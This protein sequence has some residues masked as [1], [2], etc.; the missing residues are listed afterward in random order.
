M[1]AFL[2]TISRST[3]WSRASCNTSVFR[4]SSLF[5]T[6]EEGK[7]ESVGECEDLMSTLAYAKRMRSSSS[8]SCSQPYSMLSLALP[9]CQHN[10]LHC[11]RGPKE[12]LNPSVIA[13]KSVTILFY[14]SPNSLGLSQDTAAFSLALAFSIPVVPLAAVSIAIASHLDRR[15]LCR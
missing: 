6:E 1:K 3:N 11:R 12:A 13:H 7:L 2:P 5:D 15:T 4:F 9:T 8:G 10:H 14:I